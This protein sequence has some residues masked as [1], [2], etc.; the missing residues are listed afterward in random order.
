MNRRLVGWVAIVLGVTLLGA[1]AYEILSGQFFPQDYR[2]S[3]WVPQV[4]VA[5]FGTGA[6]YLAGIVWLAL[7]V[8]FI[9]AGSGA[10]RS[11]SHGR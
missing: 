2:A 10:L 9:A 11:R 5:S 4:L 8:A 3:W 1:G 6:I 7:G